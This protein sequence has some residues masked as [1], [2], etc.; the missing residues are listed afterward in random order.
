MVETTRS[1]DELQE[2]LN[3][4]WKWIERGL[5]DRQIGAYE[6]LETMAFYPGAPWKKG[7]WDVDHKPYA[8]AF[9][10]AF[11]K[12]GATLAT[13]ENRGESRG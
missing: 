6:A 8:E 13:T 5:F 2:T 3:F 1:A 10:K 9:Y 7:R 11:P 4:L 12:A